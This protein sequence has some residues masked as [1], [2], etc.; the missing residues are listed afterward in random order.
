ME[1]GVTMDKML[2][3]SQRIQVLM[4]PLCTAWYMAV[5][6]LGGTTGLLTVSSSL[7]EK[8]VEEAHRDT[9]MMLTLAGDEDDDNVQ[10][11]CLLEKQDI[12]KQRAS[13]A[14]TT[15]ATTPPS[16]PSPSPK[17]RFTA[18]QY[19]ALVLLVLSLFISQMKLFHW[20]VRTQSTIAV[21]DKSIT[22]SA[23][24]HFIQLDQST[25]VYA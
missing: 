17:P 3:T 21:T 19:A 12:E 18:W 15:P 7:L 24:V 23:I 8:Q 14:P 13:D 1:D 4:V 5:M 20:I 16:S 6:L 2:E 10:E 9:Q 25:P 22:S 11:Q